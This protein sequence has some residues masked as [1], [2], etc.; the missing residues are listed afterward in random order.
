MKGIHRTILLFFFL[1]ISVAASAQ[2]IAFRRVDTIPVVVNNI[3]LNNAWAGG[4]N[5]PLFSEID[6]N[7]DGIHDLFMYDRSNNRISTFINDGTAGA[8]AW[9][10]D[11]RYI[12]KFPPINKWVRLYDYNCDGKMDLFTLSDCQCGVA[13]WRNDYDA[14]TGLHFTL[15]TQTLMETYFPPP[16][17]ETQ[18]YA[19]YVSLPSFGDV[20]GDGDMDI[21]GYNSISDGRILYHKNYSVENGHGCDSLEFKLDNLH[22]GN[23]QLWIGGSNEVYCYNCRKLN[24]ADKDSSLQQEAFQ[25]PSLQ[26]YDQSQAARRD[27]SISSVFMIDMDGDGDK[28]LL[29]GDSGSTNTL[30]VMNGGTPDTARMDTA[31]I[32]FPSLDIPVSIRNFPVHSYIDLDN[33]SIK[34]LIAAPTDLENFRGMWFYKNTAKTDSPSFHFQNNSFLV[35]QMI[36]VG[37]GACP[38][39]FDYD[40]DGIKDL[41]I[42]S[43]GISQ[44]GGNYKTGLQLYKNTG[45]LTSPAFRLVDYDY[46]NIS[47]LNL[48]GPVYPAF[49]DLDG[50]GDQDMLIGSDDGKLIFYNNTGGAGDTARFP[51]L[52]ANYM[53]IDAGNMSTPQIIDLN[54]DSLPDIVVGNKNGILK[55]YQNTGTASAPFFLS[56]PTIDTLGGINV[57]VIGSPDGYSVPFFFDDNG[58]YKLLLSCEKGDVYLYNNIDGN[59]NGSFRLTDTIISQT[60]GTRFRFNLA[61]SGGDLN[62]DGLTDMLLGIYGGGVQVY[63]QYHPSAI[64]ELPAKTNPAFVIAPNPAGSECSIHFMNLPGGGKNKLTVSNYLGQQLFSRTLQ[65]DHFSFD[66][67]QFAAGVYL[68]QLITSVGM[69]TQKLVVEH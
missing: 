30:L 32:T 21:L 48:P 61:V 66:T 4:I 23:F 25:D 65:S 54:R 38:V 60:Q 36:D 9:H 15:V 46:M 14:I 35:D 19:D 57:H 68:V 33:D 10:Y 67:K 13:V 16:N 43:F 29:I 31:D 50:D 2:S 45:T 34:D 37:E 5:Y 44:F 52:T 40:G 8:Y 53:G 12:S 55:Y 59:L 42:G 62:N 64:N 47:S 49:G 18:V 24:H 63:M 39:L 20:D 17:P 56:T 28:D 41:V 6:L 7:G 51:V 58:S 11:P 3:T 27:D 26:E 22:W 69:V 1:F